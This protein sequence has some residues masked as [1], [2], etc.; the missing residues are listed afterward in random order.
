MPGTWKHDPLTLLEGAVA[1]EDLPARFERRDSNGKV[2]HARLKPASRES[3]A[4]FGD[5]QPQGRRIGNPFEAGKDVAQEPI[6]ARRPG[7]G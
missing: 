2:D 6:L 5:A 3:E 1:G 4:M 7:T